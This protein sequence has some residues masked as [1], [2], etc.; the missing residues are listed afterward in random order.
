MAKHVE[1]MNIDGGFEAVDTE[2]AQAKAKG[3]GGGKADPALPKVTDDAAPT[4]ELAT[5]LEAIT[6]EVCGLLRGGSRRWSDIYLAMAHVQRDELW[7]VKYH[8][9]TDW[10][11]NVAKEAKIQVSYL[12]RVRKAGAF[13]AEYAERAAAAGVAHKALSEVEYGDEM[14]ADVARICGKDKARADRIM[15][16]ITSGQLSKSD[17]KKMLKTV[18]TARDA[19]ASQGADDARE[20]SETDEVKQAKAAAEDIL[21]AITPDALL[22]TDVLDNLPAPLDSERRIFDVLPEFPVKTGTSDHARRMDA[23]VTTNIGVDDIH[24]CDQY[25]VVL[26]CVEIKVSKYDLMNDEKHLDYM[27][28]A[29]FCWLAVPAELAAEAEKL[30]EPEGWGVLTYDSETDVLK[31]SLKAPRNAN[32]VMRERAVETVLVKRLAALSC[33]VPTKPNGK[34]ESERGASAGLK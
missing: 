34:D 28:F 18:R 26:H 22:G 4:G 25:G 9:F 17:I 1:Q 24:G 16:K 15:A 8:S 13:Y 14:L 23:L 27:P 31:P 20:S 19:A 33:A 6:T 7:K 3:K 30:A 11:K 10:V 32:A 2:A 12:W 21:L 29:D 5:E